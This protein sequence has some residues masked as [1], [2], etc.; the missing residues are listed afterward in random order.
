MKLVLFIPE[1]YRQLLTTRWL[2]QTFD[3]V[4]EIDSTS[5]YLKR[6]SPQKISHGQVLLAGYQTK[7]HGQYK[8]N[9]ESAAE[10]NLTFTLALRPQN[11]A[12]FHILTLACARA[13]TAQIEEQLTCTSTIKWPNDVFVEGKKIAGL[14][15]ETVFNG[16]KFDRLLIG[17]GI[18]VNQT[19]FADEIKTKAGSLKLTHGHE[20][21]REIFL[22]EYLS[23]VEFE[24]NRWHKQNDDQLKWIN[25]KIIGYG[26]WVSLK[27]ED[28]PQ[29]GKFKLLGVDQT[30]RLAVIDDEGGL[31]TFSYEQIRVIAD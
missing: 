1:K 17:I 15:T 22:S 30:G 2:G 12:R 11:A 5:S 29:P 13:L 4:K 7:G 16:N 23:R 6:L 9:W 3:Y 28:E 20:I 25:Q 24:Y 14:L 27:I 21:D 31:K 18:N 10:E 19:N 26:K 8:R